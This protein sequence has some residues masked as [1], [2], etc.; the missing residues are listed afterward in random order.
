MHYR[1][2]STQTMKGLC[3]KYTGGYLKG[4]ALV[5]F[6]II[7]AKRIKTVTAC[8]II[9]KKIGKSISSVGLFKIREKGGGRKKRTFL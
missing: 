8:N 7:K 2:R 3:Q 5:K 9:G 1:A 6:G 4:Y